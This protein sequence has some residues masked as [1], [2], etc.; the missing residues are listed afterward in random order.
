MRVTVASSLGK[1]FQNRSEFYV[2]PSS[3]TLFSPE[4]PHMLTFEYRQDGTREKKSMSQDRK[5]EV[6]SWDAK[7]RDLTL[8]VPLYC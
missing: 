5:L 4:T 3:H 1:K 2:Y 6:D 8:I 7:Q